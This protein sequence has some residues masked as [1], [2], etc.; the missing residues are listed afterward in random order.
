MLFLVIRLLVFA[1]AA[2]LGFSTVPG[3]L[4][5]SILSDADATNSALYSALYC[6]ALLSVVETVV[7]MCY[8][9]LLCTDPAEVPAYECSLL[10]CTACTMLPLFVWALV[11]LLDTKLAAPLHLALAVH[12]ILFSVVIFGTGTL[13]QNVPD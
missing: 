13:A 2:I 3:V 8:L 6:T 9:R 12:C 1:A 11:E 5:G 7:V 4:S 10:A